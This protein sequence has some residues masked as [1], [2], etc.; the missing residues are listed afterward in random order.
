[1]A[2]SKRKSQTARRVAAH[3]P[4]QNT[5]KRKSPS[6]DLSD[7]AGVESVDSPGSFVK[8]QV[9]Y[10]SVEHWSADLS[11]A[12]EG[13]SGCAGSHPSIEPGFPTYAQYKAIESKYLSSLAATK[14]PKA[15]ISQDTFDSIWDLLN[16]LSLTHIRTA[17]FRFW[18]RKMFTLST[19][20]QL[21][22]IKPEDSTN[23]VFMNA[24][25]VTHRGR[26]VAVQEQLYDIL[27]FCHARSDHGGRD[28]TCAIV[29]QHY[30]WV[31]KEL[32]AMFVKACS[33][34]TL[35]RSG[36]D[37]DRYLGLAVEPVR[38]W[39]DA[40]EV[41]CSPGAAPMYFGEGPNAPIIRDQPNSLRSSVSPSA[42]LKRQRQTVVERILPQSIHID[43]GEDPSSED[44]SRAYDDM[45]HFSRSS[46]VLD[47]PGMCQ[48]EP[49]AYHLSTSQ[50]LSDEGFDPDS[51]MISDPLFS[52]GDGSSLSVKANAFS[53][54]Q[55]SPNATNMSDEEMRSIGSQSDLSSWNGVLQDSANTAGNLALLDAAVAADT[56][57]PS[58]QVL[59]VF[60]PQHLDP[61]LLDCDGRGIGS[62]SNR[63]QPLTANMTSLDCLVNQAVAA[64]AA[65]GLDPPM[66]IRPTAPPPPLKLRASTFFNNHRRSDFDSPTTPASADS[67][68]SLQDDSLSSADSSYSAALSTPIDKPCQGEA[69]KEL[70]AVTEGLLMLGEISGKQALSRDEAQTADFATV[71]WE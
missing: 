38:H 64:I 16:D 21:G 63:P 57:P 15:L 59:K 65:K 43:L 49:E 11:I 33:I 4:K 61:A 17:Q 10:S 54:S 67:Y 18:V 62:Y 69:T 5:S 30:S 31:P 46:R 1:M 60:T 32:T 39:T 27:V 6:S 13:S 56:L 7:A 66:L 45:N 19:P 42:P 3:K 35:K 48:S 70:V 22:M 58:L 29:K 9:E 41:S 55:V 36:A 52:P 71:L 12:N 47:N 34:C 8:F 68:L 23:P 26:P 44:L 25:V 24:L 28:K 40:L 50:S 20:W 53:V 37:I 2:K 14:K 51:Q